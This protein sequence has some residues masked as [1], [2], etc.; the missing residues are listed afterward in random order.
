MLLQEERGGD[1][2]EQGGD[3]EERGG[4]EEERGGDEEEGGGGVRWRQLDLFLPA[5][6][7]SAATRLLLA[8]SRAMRFTEQAWYC[9]VH[10][11]LCCI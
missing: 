2:E 8:L 10:N 5:S 11:P 9:R 3:E 7:S 1:E 4:D 6:Q